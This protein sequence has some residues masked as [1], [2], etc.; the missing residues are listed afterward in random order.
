[1][2]YG[3]ITVGSREYVQFIP[4]PQAVRDGTVRCLA[5]GQIDEDG[6]HD[7]AFCPGMGGALPQT[8]NV[9]AFIAANAE[10][11]VVSGRAFD[12]GGGTYKLKNLRRF[13]FTLYESRSMGDCHPRW[14]I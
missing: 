14:D 3:K 8:E 12:G 4:H 9:K 10:S 11:P 6:F 5:C 7:K 2:G 13:R 1:M